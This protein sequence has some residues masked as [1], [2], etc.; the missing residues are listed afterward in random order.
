MNNPSKQSELAELKQ[1]VADLESQI[2][3]KAEHVPFKPSGYYTAYYAT[4]GFML[5][6]FGGMA[7]LLFNS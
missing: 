4:T 6:I 3:A 5:G 7:S 1:R 2:V